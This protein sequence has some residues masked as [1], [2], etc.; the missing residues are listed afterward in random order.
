MCVCVYVTCCCTIM[1]SK[2]FRPE[3]VNLYVR[4]IRKEK[5]K[6]YDTGT[7]IHII[8]KTVLIVLYSEKFY[9]LLVLVHIRYVYQPIGYVV[10]PVHKKQI[11]LRTKCIFY[12]GF[13][14][15]SDNLLEIFV[16]QSSGI[17]ICAHSSRDQLYPKCGSTI[18]ICPCDTLNIFCS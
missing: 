1:K 16:C 9:I 2:Q 18:C 7:T 11:A 14:L 3:N 6:R 8:N 12:R 5:K 15:V 4:E 10:T 13:Y 17:T